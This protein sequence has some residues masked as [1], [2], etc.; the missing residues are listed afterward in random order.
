MVFP[1]EILLIFAVAMIISSIGFKNYVWFIS[2][3]YGLSIAGE[4]LAMLLI[5]NKQL[6]LGTVIC[7]GLLIAYGLRLGGYLISREIGNN[8]YKKNM[9]GEIKDGKL[10]PLGVK[11]AI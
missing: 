8:S 1:V 10:V 2:I 7:C 3:G 5:Y 11:I 4:G 6:S 9:K